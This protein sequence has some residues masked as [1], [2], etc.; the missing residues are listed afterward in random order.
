MEQNMMSKEDLQGIYKEYIERKGISPGSIKQY[1]SQV[2][3]LLTKYPNLFGQTKPDLI[4]NLE[5]YVSQRRRVYH[6]LSALK[7]LFNLVKMSQVFDEFY[8]KNRRNLKPMLRKE[9]KKSLSRDQIVLMA[10]KLRE[11][12]NIVFMIEYET[13]LRISASK[14]FKVKDLSMDGDKIRLVV[15][16][17]GGMMMVKTLHAETSQRLLAWIRAN[18]LTNDS[19]VFTFDYSTILKQYQRLSKKL[20]DLKVTTHWLRTSRAIHM[21]LGIPQKD[22]TVKRYSLLEIQQFLGHKDP[23]TTLRYLMEAGLNMR[24]VIELEE[25]IWN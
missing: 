15:R 13:A 3:V 14:G 7:H 4:A 12:Y 17:K 1:C 5:H 22:G 10:E 9:L 6:Q 24:E 25:T 11:P 21:A 19:P 2:S 23:K 8:E 18:K 16:E 20:F